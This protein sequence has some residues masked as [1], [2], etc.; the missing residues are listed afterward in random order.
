MK[1]LFANGSKELFLNVDVETN[2]K[3]EEFNLEIE[4]AEWLFREHINL[5]NDIEF[6]DGGSVTIE[7]D[8]ITFQG[9]NG[10]IELKS[11]KIETL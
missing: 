3:L 6:W 1:T 8:S 5:F 10:L 4:L 9:D 2:D 7:D 11:V